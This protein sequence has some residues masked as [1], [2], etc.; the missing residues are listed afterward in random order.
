MFAIKWPDEAGATSMGKLEISIDRTSKACWR[1]LTRLLALL[2]YRFVVVV[3]D[4]QFL[5]HHFQLER[6]V[7]HLAQV[8]VVVF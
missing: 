2:P 8:D 7:L 1:M 5:L 3:E 6:V 4:D